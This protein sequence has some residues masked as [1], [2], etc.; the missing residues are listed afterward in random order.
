MTIFISTMSTSEDFK[1][2]LSGDIV[3]PGDHDYEEAISRWAAGAVRRAKVVAFVKTDEDVSRA[4]KYASAQEL[5]VGV[6]CGGHSI[7][8]ASSAENGLVIDLSR[9]F[10]TARV[11]PEKKLAYV[12]GGAVWATVEQAAIRHGLAT[13]GGTVN[14]VSKLLSSAITVFLN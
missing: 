7:T 11:D 6:R 12:G 2:N 8:G 3:V 10:N 13:V 5:T 9:H 14:H 1:N 4:I